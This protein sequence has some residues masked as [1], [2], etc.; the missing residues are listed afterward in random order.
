MVQPFSGNEATAW[1]TSAEP[2]AQ[3]AYQAL[4]G[5]QITNCMFQGVHL[6]GWA[7]LVGWFACRWFNWLAAWLLGWL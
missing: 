6:S 1:G 4:T 5:Q 2:R 7:V 3:E